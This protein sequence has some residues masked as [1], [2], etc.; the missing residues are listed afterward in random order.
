MNNYSPIRFSILHTSARPESWEKVYRNWLDNAMFPNLVQYVLVID[1]RWGFTSLQEVR[2]KMPS[3]RADIVVWNTGRRCY[4]DG[5][6]IAAQYA[7][8]DILI[9]NADDQFSCTG[10]DRELWDVCSIKGSLKMGDEY[11]VSVSTGTPTEH[12]RNIMVMPILSRARYDRLGYVF[13]PMYESMFADN[14]FAEHAQTDNCVIEARDLMFPHRHPINSQAKWDDQ[15]RTQNR[16]SAYAYEHVLHLRRREKFGEINPFQGH[17]ATQAQVKID[18]QSQ[19][20]DLPTIAVC[21]PG[22]HYSSAWVSTWTSLLVMLANRANVIPIFAYCSDVRI[23]RM[24]MIQAAL[25]HTPKVD[26]LLWIDD[27]NLVSIEQ[28]E[29]LKSTL[30]GNKAAG[31]VAGWCWITTDA[32]EQELNDWQASFGEVGDAGLTHSYKLTEIKDRIEVSGAGPIPVDYTGF[33]VVLM[34]RECAESVGKKGFLPRLDSRQ[35][36]G[37]YGED[38]GFCVSARELGYE[39]LVDLRVKVPHLKLGSKEPAGFESEVMR[40]ANIPGPA[41]LTEQV[42][43]HSTSTMSGAGE[44]TEERKEVTA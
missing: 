36:Y 27:D 33:P 40:I 1:K 9:V 7:T 5:V 44:G 24:C 38:V 30:D 20:S 18:G 6:N 28:F 11:V 8:G 13:Y 14:D 42:Q 35:P 19:G 17:F 32:W 25:D 26:Y 23:T 10:W 15:Y 37:M 31:M 41:E 12:E 16:S 21:L 34:T 29:Q 22:D 39:V 3:N 2:S 4:V 43:S